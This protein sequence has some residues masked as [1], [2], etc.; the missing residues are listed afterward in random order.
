[1]KRIA[2]P[3]PT[4]STLAQ[5]RRAR[6]EMMLRVSYLPYSVFSNPG[7]SLNGEFELAASDGSFS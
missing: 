5:L 6:N 4:E 2:C 7:M 1:M 3:H